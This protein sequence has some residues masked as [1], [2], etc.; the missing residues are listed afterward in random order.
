[1]FSWC[2]RSRVIGAAV[3]MLATGRGPPIGAEPWAGD[4]TQQEATG[5]EEDATR[6]A[7][8]P[9]TKKQREPLP[10]EAS[11]VRIARDGPSK[12]LWIPRLILLP[13]QLAAFVVTAPVAAS[14][15]TCERFKLRDR[16][17]GI[18]FNDT[19]TLGLYPIADYET[20]YGLSAGAR[21]IARDLFDGG[22]S[23]SVRAS[24][25]GA[26]PELY[27]EA[28]QRPDSRRARRARGPRLLRRGRR[29]A[30]FRDRQRRSRRATR[31]AD[32]SARR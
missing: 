19:E 31:R 9:T 4:E 25:G 28:Q 16:F 32:R 29:L 26:R 17:Y 24:F 14:M 1:V 18:F 30:V 5:P 13:V 21:L 15:W 12:W 6:E 10:R 3:V 20:G 8:P 22:G 2:E 27:V 23:A 11:G 7:K